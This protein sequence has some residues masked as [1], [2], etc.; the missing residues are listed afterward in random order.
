MVW[1]SVSIAALELAYASPKLAFL[2]VLY[3]FGLVRLAEASTW[4]KAFYPGLAVGLLS[5]VLRLGFFWRI[6]SAGAV[7]LWL[8]YAFWIGLFVALARLCL[9]FSNGSYSSLPTRNVANVRWG[10]FL[11]PF[12]WCGIEY[13]RSELYYLKFSWLSPAFAFGSTPQTFPFSQAGAYGAGFLLMGVAATA[14][15]V[16]NKSWLRSAG[17]LSFGVAMLWSAA[18]LAPTRDQS[19]PG[20]TLQVAG[21]QMEFPTESELLNRLNQ[22]LPRF[23]SAQV[24]VLSEYTFDG[25]VPDRVKAWCRQH[26]RYLIVG[27]KDPAAKGNYCDTAF[28]VGPAGE[29]VFRQGKSVP[30]QFFKDGLPALRQE[31]WDS[32]WGKVGLCVC[33]DLSYSRVTDRLVRLGAQALIV[34]TMDLADWGQP[35]HEMH[36]RVGP[37]R[38]AEYGI[39]IL[40]VASSGISQLMDCHGAELARAPYPGEGA[41]I[42]GP[43]KLSTPGHLP[44]DR[45]VA[46]FSTGVTTVLIAFFAVREAWAGMMAPVPKRQPT[47]PC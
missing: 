20:H 44:W 28:V 17:V 15:W 33:Y 4:R 11:I 24:W 35:Q 38:A 22:A 47:T 29:V 7:A 10:W 6:F 2:T 16:A 25:P 41:I 43:M 42:A 18:K 39:P 31:L 37:V 26:H 21:I 40:R 27:G 45:W 9:E 34:P 14:A 5:G 46:P 36:S 3:L 30:I 1:C 12:V 13:F 19:G 32:P 8:V 23:R